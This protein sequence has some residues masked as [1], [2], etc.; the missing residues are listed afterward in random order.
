MNLNQGKV[1]FIVIAII[2]LVIAI[3]VGGGIFL[4]NIL[5]NDG[6][7]SG[8]EDKPIVSEEKTPSEKTIV[9][10]TESKTSDSKREIHI[11]MP[12]ISSLTDYSF[13]Q[14]INKRMSDTVKYYQNEINVVLD[15][16]TPVITKYRYNVEYD[17]YNNGNYLSIVIDQDYNTGGMRSN[18]WKDTYN[19]DV[20]R[21]REI[22]LSDL[23]ES[24]VDYKKE[25][26]DEINTQAMLKNYELVG[27]NGLKDIPDKQKF[28][29]K[30]GKLIIYFD[31][32]AIAP[33]V[34]GSLNFEMPFELKDGKF[35][36][37]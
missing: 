32:A 3:L 14:Y 15:E 26:I 13:Q 7:I 16:N 19:I 23:F 33:Y 17:R 1:K 8:D 24:T 25:I 4:Y 37:E 11:N 29:I 20:V 35:N 6:P 2:I 27:G 9:D 21:N 31:P 5:N 36:V 30:D 34:Y 28:Y 12:R 10:T 18:A 22:Y